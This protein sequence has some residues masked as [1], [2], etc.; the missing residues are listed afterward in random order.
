VNQKV[1]TRQ[2]TMSGYL[3]D[4]AN[5]GKEAVEKFLHGNYD[6]IFMDVVSRRTHSHHL[7]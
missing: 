3:C 6:L 4:V 2:L 1:L 5:D 7:K